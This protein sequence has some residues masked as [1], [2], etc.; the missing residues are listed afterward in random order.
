MARPRSA[1][2]GGET[3]SEHVDATV[4]E[5]SGEQSVAD[6]IESAS[7]IDI[8]NEGKSLPVVQSTTDEAPREGDRTS[9]PNVLESKPAVPVSTQKPDEPIAQTMAGGAGEHTPPDPAEFDKEGRPIGD[10]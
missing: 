10:A 4:T 6:T 7:G 8:G 1:P 5:T 2:E 9:M 3:V